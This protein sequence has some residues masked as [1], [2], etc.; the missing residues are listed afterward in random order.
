MKSQL[1]VSAGLA[2]PLLAA[3]NSC[4]PLPPEPGP[5]PVQEMVTQAPAEQPAVQDPQTQTQTQTEAQ[6]TLQD[7]QRAQLL[8]EAIRSSRRKL[9][10]G[11]WPGALQDAL[12]A[13]QLDPQSTEAR[14]LFARVSQLM[15]AQTGGVAQRELD[16][17]VRWRVQ[18]QADR[19]RAV[20]AMQVGD[21]HRQGER[22]DSAIE[23]YQQAKTILTHSPF[24]TSGSQLSRDIESRLALAQGE[25]QQAREDRE[26]RLLATTLE[27]QAAAERRQEIARSVRV[28]SLFEDANQAF[29]RAD[30][31]AT[32]RFLD[33]VLQEQPFHPDALAL[34]QVATRARHN[35]RMDLK[36]RN[37]QEEWVKTFDDL[38]MADVPQMDY[39]KY[40]PVRWAE[41]DK[42]QPLE[43]ESEEGMERTP[44]EQAILN[45]LTA[46]EQEFVFSEAA[47]ADWATYFQDRTGVNFFVDRSAS[48]D[49]DSDA[50]TLTDF[51]L[52]RMSASRALDIIGQQTGVRWRVENGL[53]RLVTEEFAGGRLYLAQ[54]DVRDIVDGIPDK[55]GYELKL[56]VPGEEEEFFDEFDE[57]PR[58]T[59]VDG[60]RLLELITQTISPDSWDSIEEANI[61]HM[62]GVLSVRHN[63]ET[64]EA[65]N[66]FLSDLRE[67][68]GIQVDVESRFLEVTDNFLEDIGV[69]FRGLGNSSSEGIPGRGLTARP[70]VGFDDFGRREQINAASPGPPGTGTE[71]GIFYDDGGDGDIF[72][73]TENLF[74]NTLGDRDGPSNSGGFSLQYAFLD[75]TELELILRAVTKNDRSQ[76]ISAPRLLIYNN[77]RANMAVVRQITYIKDFDVEIAQAASVANPVIG[78]VRDGL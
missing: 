47:L 34:S 52:P 64:H 7:Q 69:D 48:E 24:Y 16:A 36:R 26:E 12:D 45:Q 57:E 5:D 68:V 32:L 18:D 14:E 33:L 44:E 75:D 31:D 8:A 49:L 25:L 78:V 74:D 63:R 17:E 58:P 56:T 2:L 53:V 22:Y 66:S 67:A 54:Y 65:I 35:T 51:R 50:T 71:P 19:A 3:L 15:G 46:V 27:D 4:G 76:E 59:V 62:N 55:P 10:L 73:R 11:D 9:D 37:W 40:D 77:V 21:A 23:S 13:T 72:G 38:A 6:R 1:T 61:A 41:V 43:F 39:V 29:L 60:D 20:R 28:T 42:R 30:Y 70:N